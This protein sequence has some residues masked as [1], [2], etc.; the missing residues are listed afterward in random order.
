MSA[1]PR[2]AVAVARKPDNAKRI[3]G[4]QRGWSGAAYRSHIM[5][6]VFLNGEFVD[7]GD[8]RVSAFDAGLQ[9]GV[10]LFETMLARV[11]GDAGGSEGAGGGVEGSGG[12]GD[13]GG[14][15]VHRLGDHLDRLIASAMSLGLVSQLQR[16]ALAEA[17]CQTVERAGDEGGGGRTWFRV[18]L[19]L[20]GGDL[21]L[22][23]TDSP[24]RHDPMVMIAAQPATAY[25][26]EMFE[27]GVMAVIA[28][29]RA[30]PLNP[31]EGHKTLNYWWRLRALQDAAV[32]RAGE[33]LIFSIT[34]H[35][36]GG[37]VSS[38]FLV[39]GGEL[40]TPIARG[41]EQAVAREGLAVD[42]PT[43]TAMPS[44]VLPGI[45]RKAVM[46][47]AADLGV[48]V[49]RRML[50]IHD[51]FAADEVLL[52]NSSWGI[53][54]VVQV[55]SHPIGGG[56]PGEIGRRLREMWQDEIAL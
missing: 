14:A 27:Q 10:G 44:A 3:V 18:R 41:E 9:H 34:N 11:D 32:K 25:P 21:N 48:P 51:V 56:T 22:L 29:A 6:T 39:R 52:T 50:T 20:T 7:A 2:R 30:N 23:R 54:P 16:E 42:A 28:D 45:T 35:L 49:H 17:V 40:F 47:W 15:T 19:T 36:V 55:E 33:A 4:A 13:R 26:P 12:G 37:C 38:A 1:W 53:L 46:E 43:P 5:A 24:T 8:A 31:H